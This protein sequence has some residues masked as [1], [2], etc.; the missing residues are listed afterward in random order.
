MEA[1]AQVAA[2]AFFLGGVAPL[3]HAMR[4]PPPPQAGED[5]LGRDLSV[6]LTR[7]AGEGD[8]RSRWR[9]RREP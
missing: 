3:H 1:V 4:G 9:G 7:E 5:L 2:F 8:R 6:I